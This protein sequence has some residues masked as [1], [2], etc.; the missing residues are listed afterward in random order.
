MT[1]TTAD[2]RLC[3]VIEPHVCTTRER[4]DVLMRLHE[5][6]IP[7]IVW[8]CPILPFINDTEENIGGI[9]DIC[10]EAGVYGVVCF[11]MGLTLREGNREYFYQKLDEHFPGMSRRYQAAYGDS[12][13]V[14][15]PESAGLMRM[16]AAFCAR[17]GIVADNKKLFSFMTELDSSRQMTL[18]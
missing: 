10:R 3:K 8:L 15:S 14:A 6:G 5:A 1:L 12:Y 11:G 13:E 18:F 16:V 2:E 17:N 9:L 7:T 4:A